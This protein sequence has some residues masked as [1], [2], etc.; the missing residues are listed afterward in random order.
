[1]RGDLERIAAYLQM[2]VEEC[3]KKYFAA[4]PGSL[5]KD[6]RTGRTM[7]IGSICPK[8]H[9][10]RCVFLNEND[11]CSI[12]AVAPFG[13]AY[14]DTHMPPSIAHPRSVYMACSSASPEYQ[15]QRNDLDYA[16]SYKPNAY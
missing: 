8:M 7:R 9:K 4:S 1:V 12:H 16:T 13:C 14:F 10:S 11:Q 2:S 15:A 3:A 5:V 6:S